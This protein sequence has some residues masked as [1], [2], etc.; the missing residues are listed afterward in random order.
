[1]D[2][3]HGALTSLT[4]PLN[5]GQTQ[6]VDAGGR[7]TAVADALGRRTTR[8]LDKLD[9]PIRQTDAV[10]SET[11]ASYD[12][13]GRL[14]ILRDARTHETGF[15]YDVS[16]RLVTRT[17]PLQKSETTQYDL[18]GNVSLRTDRKG[19]T[20]AYE[21]DELDRLSRATYADN[22][23][24]TYTY[25]AG[26]RIAQIADSINGTITRQ[27]DLL[28]RLTSETT[29]TGTV[30]YT[31][32][33]ADRRATM[34]VN[35][36][37][38]IVYGYDVAD[39]LISITQGA[40]IVTLSYDDADRRSTL[41]LPNGVVAT[42]GYDASNRLTSI[43]YSSNAGVLGDLTY[44][45]DAVGN[46]SSVSGSWARTR[47]P[48]AMSGATYD[49]ANR[50][51]NWGGQILTYDADGHLSSDGQRILQWD[52]RNQLAAVVSN[53]SFTFTYDGTG[54]RRTRSSNGTTTEFSYDDLDSVQ[55]RTNGVVTANLLTG[56]SVDEMFLRADAAG[57][58]SPLTDAQGTVV[59]LTDAAGSPRTYYT[60]APFGAVAVMGDTDL[61]AAMF[62]G[63]ERDDSGLYY[64][65]ARYYDPDSQ[66]FLAEDPL[67]FLA[68][69]P[70]LYAYVSNAPTNY[71]DPTGE[72]AWIGPLVGCASSAGV[73]LAID[74][75]G[76]RKLDW[77]GAG[78]DCLSGAV[79]GRVGGFARQ[80]TNRTLRKW[81][82]RVNN[83]KWPKDPATGRNQDVSHE[84][85]AK[86]DA[87]K[88]FDPDV[89]DNIRPRTAQDHRDY[90]SDRGDFGR[91]GKWGGRG[92]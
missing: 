28:D 71:T 6:F 16:D 8:V 21:Y 34:T 78:A 77:W 18:N 86:A 49:A 52:V 83:Q 91:W 69:D 13:N 89:V 4:D 25:D 17:D 88:G 29:A 72:L 65:R 57:A 82:E 42:Y 70:N 67:G 45:Y 31:Y 81:W 51:T 66:R 14:L 62:T 19:Q 85:V 38:S 30:G 56:L 22:S 53:S 59:A 40:S 24:I 47:L 64:Y 41:T 35:G 58:R 90:H 84:P 20:V 68:G 39:R 73:G 36:Q 23:T 75:I 54:R 48:Q 9:R 7:V 74:W 12:S 11:V 37:P 15:E 76:G 5:N 2:Y 1:M 87:P 79:A 43:V 63:R 61:N 27:F 55:E 92:K 32:D 26:D 3:E 80:V 33:A 44:T 46:R 10:G 50:T 60:Y